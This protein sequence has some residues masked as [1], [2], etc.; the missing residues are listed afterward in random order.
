MSK[1]RGLRIY[2]II[3]LNLHCHQIVMLG[4]HVAS[5]S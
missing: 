3:D 4:F 1:G 5:V 2:Y